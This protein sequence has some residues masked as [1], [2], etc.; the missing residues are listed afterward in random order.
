MNQSSKEATISEST[1]L[2]RNRKAILNDEECSRYDDIVG[3]DKL[4]ELVGTNVYQTV[5]Q[6]TPD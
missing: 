2:L 5:R 1:W 4:K 6:V 3:H